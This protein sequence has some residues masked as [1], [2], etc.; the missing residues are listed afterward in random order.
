MQVSLKKDQVMHHLSHM[1]AWISLDT[2]LLK[3]VESSESAMVLF[4]HAALVGS[5]TLKL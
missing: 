3:K 1:L 5:Y 2:L 4:L